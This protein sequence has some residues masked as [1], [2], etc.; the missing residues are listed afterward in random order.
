[1]SESFNGVSLRALIF[2]LFSSECHEEQEVSFVSI[3]QKTQ[4]TNSSWAVPFLLVG[5]TITKHIPRLKKKQNN[6]F[7][8]KLKH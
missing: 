3:L 6:L 8:R 4:A 2:L 7:L 1:M 5:L